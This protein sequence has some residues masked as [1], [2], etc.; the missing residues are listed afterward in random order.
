[1]G[2]VLNYRDDMTSGRTSVHSDLRNSGTGAAEDLCVS[3]GR[4]T[5]GAE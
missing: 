3:K 2:S 4:N 1:M 5:P